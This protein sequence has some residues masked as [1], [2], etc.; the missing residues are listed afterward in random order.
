MTDIDAASRFQ[1]HPPPIEKIPAE[2]F[3]MIFEAALVAEHSCV[4]EVMRGESSKFY[5][6]PRT[7]DYVSPTPL[8][9][10][11]SLS[12]VSRRW[13]K[14][15][16]A[17]P[18]LWRNIAVPRFD[19]STSHTAQRQS[20][21]SDTVY[22]H[23]RHHASPA[24]CKRLVSLWLERAVSS[25]ATTTRLNI[26]HAH[27]PSTHDDPMRVPC[28]SEHDIDSY[29]A[30]STPRTALESAASFQYLRDVYDNLA[31][32]HTKWESLNLV[33][34]NHAIKKFAQLVQAQRDRFR[35]GEELEDSI[36]EVLG[37]NLKELTI[38]LPMSLLTYHD[39]HLTSL[40]AWI[41]T[42][43]SLRTFV[44]YDHFSFF[45]PGD[46]LSDLTSPLV[47]GPML[48]SLS[49]TVENLTHVQLF[50][51]LTDETVIHTLGTALAA[52]H[53]SF[54]MDSF[55]DIEK[56][57]EAYFESRATELEMFAESTSP[58]A[59]V[60]A[61]RKHIVLK[62]LGSLEL[63]HTVDPLA[64][65]NVFSIPFLEVLIIRQGILDIKDTDTKEAT[66]KLV[67][68]LGQLKQPLRKLV[69]QDDLFENGV[70]MS[71]LFTLRDSRYSIEVVDIG[72]AKCC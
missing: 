14:I 37:Q 52:R 53:V 35:K 25:G 10:P 51:P 55:G 62:N 9:A 59:V 57:G 44:L 70:D 47:G 5:A 22:H 1:S 23:H 46:V 67:C 65:I 54:S 58:N 43:P 63:A 56:R 24:A 16:L 18:S 42:L 8:A 61:D 45:S 29:A 39:Q 68:F 2:L 38:I 13:R 27:P 3:L 49:E 50:A 48:N 71:D 72:H 60:Y 20:Q 33:L 28:N 11:L 64:A 31:A 26:C 15:V 30:G 6:S 21:S 36:S 32:Y 17:S 34:D 12:Q 4:L 69:L 19:W 66:R 7:I 41:R 40:L